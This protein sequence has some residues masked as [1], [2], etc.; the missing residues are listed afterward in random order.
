MSIHSFDEK[1][2]VNNMAEN[3]YFNL[4]QQ[5]QWPWDGVDQ[6][7]WIGLVDQEKVRRKRGT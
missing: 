3:N 1:Q 4:Y 6:G 5:P 7:V 2:V